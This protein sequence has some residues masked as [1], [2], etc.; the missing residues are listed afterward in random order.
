[1]TSRLCS[2]RVDMQMKGG[3]G[4]MQLR[5]FEVVQVQAYGASLNGSLTTCQ[6]SLNYY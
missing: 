6:T 5:N 1:M 3:S 4:G 2:V